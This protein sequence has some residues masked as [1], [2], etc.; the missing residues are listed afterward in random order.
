MAFVRN[1]SYKVMANLGDL[2]CS[3]WARL[4]VGCSV[5]AKRQLTQSSSFSKTKH[6]MPH[7]FA[8]VDKNCTIDH[9]ITRHTHCSCTM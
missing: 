3:A 5:C 1:V 8:N 9:M 2:A 4:R 7:I 6:S